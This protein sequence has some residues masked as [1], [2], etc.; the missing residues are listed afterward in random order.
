M[1]RA[2]TYFDAQSVR[3]ATFTA[4][5]GLPMGASCMGSALFQLALYSTVNKNTTRMV[6][7][8]DIVDYSCHAKVTSL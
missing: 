6:S 7:A 1:Q 2:G 4:G 3:P 5:D 8:S